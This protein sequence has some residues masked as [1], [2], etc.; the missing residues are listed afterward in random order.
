[1]DDWQ[2]TVLEF[3]NIHTMHCFLIPTSRIKKTS[4]I[5]TMELMRDQPMSLNGPSVFERI[6][7]LCLAVDWWVDVTVP[8]T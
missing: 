7:N 8:D 2:T 6:V 5:T 3:G 4:Q 1:V